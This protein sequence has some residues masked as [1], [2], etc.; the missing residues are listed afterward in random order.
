MP[1]I[2]VKPN[3]TTT[4]AP[5]APAGSGSPAS[6]SP[7][8]VILQQGQKVHMFG[9][10]TEKPLG[11][12]FETQSPNETILLF[13][14]RDFVTNIPWIIFSLFLAIVPTLLTLIFK[15]V[16]SPLPP[17]PIRYGVIL[18][19]FYY[20]IVATYV[21]VN[22]ITWYFNIS[23]ITDQRVVDI[24]FTDLIYTNVAETKLTLLQ[25]VSYTQIGAIRVIFDFGDVLIQTAAAID[26]FNLYAVPRPQRVVQV[27]ESLI[28]K[29]DNVT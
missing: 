10:Y 19:A 26:N 15:V 8:P 24:D 23:L 25:D 20:L 6:A 14:R 16:N 17:L 5:N 13:L 3:Q 12:S 4:P 21:F 2:F 1:D 22:F 28:G 29:E 7:T 27:V 11:V 18:L 9:A